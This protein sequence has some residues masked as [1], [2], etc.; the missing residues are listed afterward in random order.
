MQGSVANPAI[1]RSG[2]DSESPQ[3]YAMS[4][5]RW[6]VRSS[7]TGLGTAETDVSRCSSDIEQAARKLLLGERKAR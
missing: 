5:V 1:A 4:G 2:Q 3:T 7:R 6:R